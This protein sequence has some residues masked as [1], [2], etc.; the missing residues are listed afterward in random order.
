MDFPPGVVVDFLLDGA[1]RLGVVL[2]TGAN[3]VQAVDA[4]GRRHAVPVRQIFVRHREMLD[5]HHP[6]K[7]LAALHE[8]IQERAGEVD[9]ALLWQA[10]LESGEEWEPAALAEFYFGSEECCLVS[11]LLRAVLE[12]RLRFRL[13]GR[14]LQLRSERQ[15]EA[16]QEAEAR[17]RVREE[18]AR[19]VR[20]WLGALLAGEAGDRLEAPD[21]APQVLQR[22]EDF[23]LQRHGDPEVETWLA[24]LDPELTPRLA[25]YEILAS[26]GRLPAAADPLLFAAGIDPRFT[27]EA[28]E[29][30]AELSPYEPDSSRVD[31][32]H[33]AA[34]SIDDEE[35]LE[36][37]DG[38]SFEWS[39]DM[40]T[41]WIHVADL[42]PFV[43]PGDA[44]DQEG[45]KRISSVYLPQAKVRMLP[46]RLSCQLAS[47]VEGE[48]RPALS[49]RVVLHEDGTVVDWAFVRS[50]VRITRRRSYDE[51]DTLIAASDAEGESLRRLVDLA[52][53]LQE[54]RLAAGALR[55]PRPEVKVSV[56]GELIEVK[57]IE[58]DT[59]SRRLVSEMMILMNRLA[60]EHARRHEIP[61]IYRSQ[62]APAEPVEVPDTYDPVALQALFSGLERSR[63]SLEP[64]PHW[65]LG[66]ETYTQVTSPLRR[67]C[68]LVVQRQISAHLQNAPPPYKSEDLV[69]VI[70]LIQAVEG[71]LR[72]AERNSV[73]YYLLKYLSRLP[74]EV[75]TGIVIRQLEHGELVETT[76]LFVRGLLVH[77]GEAFPVGAQVRM[78]IDHVDPDRNV[79]RFRPA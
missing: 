20:R 68:D 74:D 18:H 13:R 19:L 58:A 56:R 30:A 70:G 8:R 1:L 79:L 34:W 43:H 78:K 40:V 53:R 32:T 2:S 12:D 33:L 27:R 3:K 73:R 76:D 64:E 25:A 69:E 57:V 24:G 45:R 60:A 5:P 41:L 44:L 46:E 63:L 59:P 16:D 29:R 7:D 65:G 72:A 10:A 4:H 67:Y 15:V 14:V 49:L 31:L 47:L 75:F 42:T 21:D 52:D 23:L 62:P 35:T 28:Q 48:L 17:R 77:E 11:A 36:I 39:G 61:L 51:C 54:Q 37:D 50:Q 38:F 66:V 26:L 22:L 6:G 55:L 71:D 9:T